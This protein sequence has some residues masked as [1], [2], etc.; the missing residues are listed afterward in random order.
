MRKSISYALCNVAQVMVTK[1]HM[2]GLSIEADGA[3]EDHQSRSL[4]HNFFPRSP[5]HNEAN[6]D[7]ANCRGCRFLVRAR[8]FMG[9]GK[10]NA[11]FALVSTE[12]LQREIL[13]L[14]EII[15]DLRPRAERFF[16][17][18]S[19]LLVNCRIP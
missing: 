14:Q 11:H 7:R 4:S 10:A 17:L 15:R 18:R 13:S 2:V 1:S 5:S 19:E 8:H 16:P 12:D 3:R 9:N 6:D